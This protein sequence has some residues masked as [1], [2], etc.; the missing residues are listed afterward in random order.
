[1]YVQRLELMAHLYTA[2]RSQW[3]RDCVQ[4]LQSFQTDQGTYRFPSGYLREG[5]SGYWVSGAY[6]RLEENRRL[7]GSL[8]L[9]STF[10]MALIDRLAR[11]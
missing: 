1:M 9:D 10:R 6:M 5:S 2:R 3:F 7:R 11:Q 8:D 4:H